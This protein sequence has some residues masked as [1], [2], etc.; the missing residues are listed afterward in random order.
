MSQ[1]LS[2]IAEQCLDLAR[3]NGA[4]DADI[5]VVNGISESVDVE[6]GKLE[7][8]ER[9]EGTDLGLRV[10]IGK[11]QAC[12]SISD[13]SKGAIQAMT[14][15]AVAMAKAA[16]EDSYCGLA[17]EGELG[18]KRDAAGLDLFDPSNPPSS[19]KLLDAALSAEA[20]ALEVKGVSKAQG[21]SSGYSQTEVHIL[22]SGG[23]SGGYRRSGYSTS[24]VAIA[25]EGLAMER[26]WAGEMRI[27]ASDVP[28]P[29]EIGTLAGER[30]VE[31]FGAGRA[32]KGSYPVLFD[33]RV[34]SSLIGHLMSAINGLSITRGS[35]F[36]KDA[37]GAQ[38]LPKGMDLFEEPLRPRISGSKPFDAEGLE[39]ARRAII[40]DGELKTWTLD[41]ATARQLGMRSTANAARGV[42]SPPNPS[43]GNLSLSQSTKSKEDLMKEMGSGLL[44]TSMIGST[45][46]PNT[47]DYSR[48]AAG[49]WVENGEPQYPVN[50]LTIASNLREMFLT[51]T[52]ANDARDHLSRLVPSL[53]IESMTIASS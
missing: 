24:C 12:V 25:G 36:L 32:P 4:E 39:T 35:S 30:A 20:Y 13:L 1:N 50:E 41:L 49:M 11:R 18:S 38:I 19:E 2:E 14:E 21:A 42:T 48:G 26:D 47:G 6:S 34:S 29:E 53:L 43:A 7:K 51:M 45:I 31:R 22:T 9:S 17:E 16:P 15:R 8:V 3:K 40:E 27:Y 37:M 46:N 33:E 28:A 10:L 23:F 52:P 5:L 44:V